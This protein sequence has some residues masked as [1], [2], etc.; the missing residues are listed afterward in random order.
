[1]NKEPN[2]YVV[3]SPSGSYHDYAKQRLLVNS[4]E[5]VVIDYFSWLNWYNKSRGNSNTNAIRESVP[6]PLYTTPDYATAQQIV[7]E[8]NEK[9]KA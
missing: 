7:K 8:L 3:L 5:Y 2:S 6:A 9:I 4:D 1:M